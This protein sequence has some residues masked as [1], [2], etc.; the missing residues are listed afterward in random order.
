MLG[1]KSLELIHTRLFSLYFHRQQQQTISA[2]L[3]TVQLNV[4]NFNDEFSVVYKILLV[5]RPIQTTKV[6]FSESNILKS[7]IRLSENECITIK[8]VNIKN[9]TMSHSNR[10]TF[11]D[12]SREESHPWN[13]TLS[14]HVNARISLDYAARPFTLSVN[15]EQQVSSDVILSIYDSTHISTF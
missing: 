1:T 10:C 5:H 12:K 13:Y 8:Y 11:E 3:E 2:I 4:L 6:G 14:T 15:K 7:P 9:V